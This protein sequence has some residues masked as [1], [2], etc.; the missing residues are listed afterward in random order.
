VVIAEAQR[1][2]LWV[3]IGGLVGEIGRADRGKGIGKKT[4]KSWHLKMKWERWR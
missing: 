2:V 3:V 1:L 4:Q